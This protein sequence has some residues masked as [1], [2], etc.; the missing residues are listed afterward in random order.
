[1]GRSDFYRRPGGVGA[2]LTRRA[3]ETHGTRSGALRGLHQH[4]SQAASSDAL[5]RHGD[6]NA[7]SGRDSQEKRTRGSW[8]YIFF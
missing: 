2:F 5:H 6:M 3:L 4:P 1:M 8:V 7:K